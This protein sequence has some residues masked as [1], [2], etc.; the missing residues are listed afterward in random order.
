MQP[1]GEGKRYV[2]IMPW[3]M[4]SNSPNL[5]IKPLLHGKN[6]GDLR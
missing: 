3:I 6:S 4:P 2:T 1:A 5:G